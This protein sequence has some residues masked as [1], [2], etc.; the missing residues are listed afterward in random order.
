MSQWTRIIARFGGGRA[1]ARATG[2]AETTVRGWKRVGFIPA[3]HQMTVLAAGQEL[4]PP[5]TPDDFFFESE[6]GEDGAET[7]E[8][9]RP[10]AAD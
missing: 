8:R 4:D 9:G 10:A 2:L 3:H 5:L 6:G 1:T 7:Q